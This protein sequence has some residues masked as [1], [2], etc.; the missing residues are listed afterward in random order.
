[1]KGMWLTESKKY[2]EKVNDFYYDDD[3]YWALR[4]RCMNYVEFLLQAQ[5][6]ERF[7]YYGKKV[8]DII[9][10]DYP[11]MI[12]L[13]GYWDNTEYKSVNLLNKEYPEEAALIRAG[14]PQ[15]IIDEV[16]EEANKPKVRKRRSES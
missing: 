12:K 14:F 9:D 10:R 11:Q 16:M 8:F 1:M 7:R 4:R 3:K 15:N 2:L 13:I 5:G 6:V